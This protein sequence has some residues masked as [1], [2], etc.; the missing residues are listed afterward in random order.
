MTGVEVA[1]QS[2]YRIMVEGKRALDDL[3]SDMGRMLAESIMLIEREELSGPD[4][5]PTN[6]KLQKWSHE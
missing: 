4:Y 1:Q 5:Y 2:L 6:S 3:Y